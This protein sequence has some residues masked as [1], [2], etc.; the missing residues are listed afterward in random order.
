VTPQVTAFQLAAKVLDAAGVR[1]WL[2]DGCVL[3]AVREGRLLPGDPDV[4]LGV[5]AADMPT[6]RAAFVEAMWPL[7]RDRPG[8][9]WAVHGGVKVDLHGHVPDGDRVW[10]ELARGRLAYRFPAVLFYSLTPVELHG[11]QTRMPSPPEAYCESHYG[12]RWRTPAAR[13]RWDRDPPCVVPG[14][15]R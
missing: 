10:Y 7:R 8:Q 13:W 3:G 6:V 11:V 12:P 1:W 9:L 5:W 15:G 14:P 4:D 2:S